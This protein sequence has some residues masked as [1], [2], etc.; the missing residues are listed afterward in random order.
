[1]SAMLGQTMYSTKIL[2][3]SLVGGEAA[4]GCKR[5]TRCNFSV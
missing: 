3:Y 2:V 1:M 4:K 5:D